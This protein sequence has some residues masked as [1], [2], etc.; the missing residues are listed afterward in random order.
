M[1]KKVYQQ[2]L[3]QLQQLQQQQQEQLQQL[4]QQQQQQQQYHPHSHQNSRDSR[5]PSVSSSPVVTPDSTLSKASPKLSLVMQVFI[6]H[7]SAT[8]ELLMCDVN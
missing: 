6:H 4:L 8:L 7:M 5:E 1:L 3:Q 2:Q